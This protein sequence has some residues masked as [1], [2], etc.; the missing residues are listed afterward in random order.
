MTNT[1]EPSSSRLDRIE[2]ILE[3]TATRL[4]RVAEQQ[5]QNTTAIAQLTIKV[6]QNT[7]AIAELKLELQDSISHLVGVIGDF[8]E[9]AHNDREQAKADRQAFR[10]Q[11]DRLTA[12]A[13]QDRQQA[14]I[15]RQEFRT[16]I[17][18]IWEY[19]R[20][21]NGGSSSPQ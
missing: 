4:D 21:R 11:I 7:D 8:V 20:D 16:E 6:D 12:E 5:E 14:A 19:L 9:E 18:R 1:P 17:R 10:E 2:R 13:A 3:Q 15:D